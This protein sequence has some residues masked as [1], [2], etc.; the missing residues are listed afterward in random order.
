M[1]NV[2]LSFDDTATYYFLLITSEPIFH[3]TTE[4][5]LC[6]YSMIQKPRTERK[7][8]HHHCDL[9]KLVDFCL[10]QR[11]SKALDT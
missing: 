8:E 5:D 4:R 3:T 9:W 1:I 2:G 6:V 10:Y 11:Y 7:I